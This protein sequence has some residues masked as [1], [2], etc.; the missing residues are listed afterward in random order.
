MYVYIHPPS[1]P[2]YNMQLHL[3]LSLSHHQMIAHNL[4]KKAQ[5]VT[6]TYVQY[7]Y[8][9]VQCMCLQIV[10]TGKR[11]LVDIYLS[12]ISSTFHSDT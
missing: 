9:R 6:T 4:K 7:M 3:V 10:C 1:S 5:S 2:L 11:T 12:V 8:I